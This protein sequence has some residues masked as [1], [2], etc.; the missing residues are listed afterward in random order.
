M[1]NLGEKDFPGGKW[2]DSHLKRAGEGVACCKMSIKPLEQTNLR[3][4]LELI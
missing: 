3:I 4:L 2:S 1:V